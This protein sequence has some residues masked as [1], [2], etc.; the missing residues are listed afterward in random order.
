[1]KLKEIQREQIRTKS[2]K[3]SDET[4]KK[5]KI[6]GAFT[7]RTQNEVLSDLL[8]EALEKLKLPSEL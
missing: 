1:M 2:M 3:A 5:L 6:L 8:K 4:F 7:Q